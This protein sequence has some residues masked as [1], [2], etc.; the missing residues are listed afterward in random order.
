MCCQS[1]LADPK[2]SQ[3]KTK[4]NKTKQN[5]TKQNK[6]KQTSKQKNKQGKTLEHHLVVDARQVRFVPCTNQVHLAIPP[7]QRFHQVEQLLFS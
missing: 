7:A 3:Y 5:K 4:Q 2:E 6:T 1:I